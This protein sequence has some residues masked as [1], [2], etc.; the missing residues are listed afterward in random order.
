MKN[1]ARFD[2]KMSPHQRDALAALAAEAGLS[3]ADVVPVRQLDARASRGA[4][5]AI[6]HC[7]TSEGSSV[8]TV[9]FILMRPTNHLT[10]SG[11]AEPPCHARRR[12]AAQVS[13]RGGRY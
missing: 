12:L 11:V 3:S 10:G 9:L 6:R 1:V 8:S 2:L 4:D 7:R 5:A 13:R